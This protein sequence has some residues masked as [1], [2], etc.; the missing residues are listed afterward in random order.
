VETL[1]TGGS[2]EPGQN[3]KGSLVCW[4]SFESQGTSGRIL[5]ACSQGL[6]SK[7]PPTPG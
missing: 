3:N 1:L 7:P 6:A 4:S 2:R 5:A